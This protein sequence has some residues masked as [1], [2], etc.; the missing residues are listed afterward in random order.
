MYPNVT[1]AFLLPG[2]T[3]NLEGLCIGLR[4]PVSQRHLLELASHCS[5]MTQSHPQPRNPHCRSLKAQCSPMALRLVYTYM[6][7]WPYFLLT[8]KKGK[9]TNIYR[10]SLVCRYNAR[11]FLYVIVRP[12]PHPRKSW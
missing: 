2:A 3:G 6:S 8:L 9:R 1:T 5:Y 10:A 4:M 11:C 7:S 12:C